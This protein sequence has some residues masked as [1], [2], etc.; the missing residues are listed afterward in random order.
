MRMVVSTDRRIQV[1]GREREG[2][3]GPPY[4]RALEPLRQSASI[5]VVNASACFLV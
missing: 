1:H 2:Y 5:S 3:L 4:L